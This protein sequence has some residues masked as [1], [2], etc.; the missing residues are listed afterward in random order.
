MD[1]FNSYKN[2]LLPFLLLGNCLVLNFPHSFTHHHTLFSQELVFWSKRDCTSYPY[3][4]FCTT[5]NSIIIQL[6]LVKN[7]Y[8]SLKLL[9]Y[10]TLYLKL[11]YTGDRETGNIAYTLLYGFIQ[12][13]CRFYATLYKWW[14][15]KLVCKDCTNPAGRWHSSYFVITYLFSF[16]CVLLKPAFQSEHQLLQSASFRVTILQLSLHTI[17]K[18]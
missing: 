6:V 15:K 2:L 16:C 13:D 9:F 3:K 8:V 10:W 12:E 1:I 7:S 17:L 14:T 4:H 18:I 11:K 5:W